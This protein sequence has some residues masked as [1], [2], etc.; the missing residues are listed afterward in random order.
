MVYLN[1][2]ANHVKILNY[3]WLCS[4]A[5]KVNLHLYQFIHMNALIINPSNLLHCIA[6]EDVVENNQGKMNY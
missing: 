6:G 1:E 2:G 4:T 5:I 3:W